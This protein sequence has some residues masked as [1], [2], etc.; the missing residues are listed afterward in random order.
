M[1]KDLLADMKADVS[2][3]PPEKGESSAVL[4]ILN[5]RGSKLME[6]MQLIKLTGQLPDD[7]NDSYEGDTTEVE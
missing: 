2:T 5:D 1:I 4:K 3:H 7:L 6:V